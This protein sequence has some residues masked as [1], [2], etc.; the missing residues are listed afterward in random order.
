MLRSFQQIKV[1]LEVEIY[2]TRI[3]PDQTKT[4]L[5]IYNLSDDTTS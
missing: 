5:L 4:M 3:E 1:P 2:K